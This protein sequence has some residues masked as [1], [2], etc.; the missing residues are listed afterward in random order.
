V[1][2]VRYASTMR[3]LAIVPFAA[4]AACSSPAPIERP[5]TPVAPAPQA[6][7]APAEP[8]VPID[9]AADEACHPGPPKP[10]ND[11]IESG[12]SQRKKQHHTPNAC[13]LTS[14]NLER[15]E[16][17]ILALKPP[18]PRAA[19]P[20]NHRGELARLDLV[21]KR[22]ALQPDEIKQ[23]REQGVVV[24]ARLGLA[25]Y[26][27]GYHE[28]FQSQ[29]PVYITADSIFDTVF[30]SHDTIMEDLEASYKGP[31]LA[32]ALQAALDTMHCGLAAAAS[33]YPPD[34]ARDLDLYL[35]VARSLSC[36]CEVHGKI[37][38]ATDARAKQL[39]ASIKAATGIEQ[40]SLFGR[41]RL[42]DFTQY[43]PRGHYATT[44]DGQPRGDYDQLPHYFR[45][46]MWAS[47]LELNLVSRS[48]RSSEPGMVP[49][50]EETPREA[51]DALALADLATRTGATKQIDALDRGW[52]VLAGKREDVS[53]AQLT[54]LREDAH[55]GS[56]KDADAFDALKR[57]IGDKFQRTTRVH[58][59]PESSTV[60]PAIAT[61]IGP[62]IVADAHAIMPLVHSA[63]PD[64]QK[65][66]A[67]DIVYSLG[68]DHAKRYLA[69]ELAKFPNL[70]GQLAIARDIIQHTPRG[71]DLYSGWLAAIRA[72]AVDPD[73]V[74]PSY[75]AN[76][77]GLDLRFNSLATAYGQLKHN[78]VLV[79]GQPY[80]EFG[81]EI[82][83][84]YVEPAPAAYAALIEYARSGE[85]LAKIVD[86]DDTLGI[87]SY[88]RRVQH[89]LGVLQA[90]AEHELA[91]REL[92]A[93]EKH[94]LGM[95]AEMGQDRSEETTGF[96]PMYS[97]WYFDLFFDT[98]A[99][100]LSSGSFVADYFTSASDGV[101]YLGATAPRMG[102]FVIDAGGAPRVA[103]GP[104]AHGFE[105][106]QAAGTRY[107]DDQAA[108]LAGEPAWARS[109]TIASTA[110]RPTALRLSA[111]KTGKV[112]VVTDRSYDRATIRILDHHRAPIATKTGKLNAGDTVFDFHT[113]QLIGAIYIEIGGFR[114]WIV[115]DA[116]DE[117]DN[118][119]WG[120]TD[121]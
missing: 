42:I 11:D 51:I 64:R 97:G 70:D 92:T 119:G 73:G 56:L 101:A 69:A 99:D 84:G 60:L 107:T 37:D 19:T 109:Y 52:A 59:M 7:V 83:D 1:R 31:T 3:R 21:E 43:Q 55:I 22:F 89:V 15:D 62:R 79:A 100:G 113:K 53:I 50:P 20:W 106:Q 33:D 46:A 28:I 65:I 74:K 4:L 9:D 66:G 32:N 91:G 49:N 103:V 54:K 34:T 41:D 8:I 111:D 118:L 30:A 94:W 6:A 90:I 85:G 95:V 117:I 67:A 76:D 88:Y 115:A 75:L 93:V 44:S 108:K 112:K 17:A 36:D 16:T 86:P 80:S 47:R 96:P 10:N 121:N 57:A 68:L 114:D 87:A 105:L 5:V 38:R 71:D 116:Y 12:D 78:Y 23:L 2:S 24:P 98:E 18:Q 29:L 39:L 14:V 81:C 45:A 63:V 110:D 58:P 26:A 35:T 120:G 13:E 48:S 25:S 102:V 40:V 61:L 104:V 27:Q 82:P 72:L 77:A